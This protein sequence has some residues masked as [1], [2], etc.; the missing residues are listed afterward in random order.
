MSATEQNVEQ[1]SKWEAVDPNSFGKGL[2]SEKVTTE[3]GASAFRQSNPIDDGKYAFLIKKSNDPKKPYTETIHFE[4]KGD[5]AAGTYYKVN[6]TLTAVDVVNEEGR[7]VRS[8]DSL[9]GKQVEFDASFDTMPK[10]DR[11]TN[12]T[13]ST[14]GSLLQLLG[15]NLPVEATADQLMATILQIVAT[16]QAMVGNSTTWRA[17]F[18]KDDKD[19]KDYGKFTYVGQKSFPLVPGGVAG[20]GPYDPNVVG[21][22]GETRAKAYLSKNGWFS[23]AKQA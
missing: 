15:V 16:G 6:L 5:K 18:V 1:K 4:A 22:K 17:D 10:K 14:L 7:P 9:K 3:E 2:Y 11:Q 8:K 19:P 21:S 12:T 23:L 13:T 20:V